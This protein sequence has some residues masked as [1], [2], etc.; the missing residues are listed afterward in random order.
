M[1]PKPMR[2]KTEVKARDEAVGT[3][4][5]L[6]EPQSKANHLASCYVLFCLGIQAPWL[7]G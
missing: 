1:S 3:N 2:K 7:M 4:A 5:G 6:K